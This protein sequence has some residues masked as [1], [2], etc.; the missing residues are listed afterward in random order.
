MAV[1][2]GTFV[3]NGS[4]N[5]AV[6]VNGGGT[7]AGNGTVGNTTINGGTLS[8]GNS[9]GTITINGNL[10]LTS[11]ATYVVEIGAVPTAPS[12][13]ARRTSPAPCRWCSAGPL[14]AALHD[15][16][17]QR[18]RDRH[19]HDGHSALAGLAQQPHLRPQQRLSEPTA[20][21][22]AAPGLN[23]NQQN[24]ATSLNTFFNG[25]GAAAGALRRSCS[26]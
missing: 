14:L 1:N 3:T 5:G 2:G 22:G 20:T 21:L 19:L 8:P 9:I 7:L 16:H 4:V 6:T 10:V 18:R 24:V 26:Q 11:A 13:R 15:P 23:Q 12:S 25:G 17:C